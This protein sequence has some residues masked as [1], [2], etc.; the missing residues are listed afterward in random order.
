MAAISTTGDI[1]MANLN[2]H[3]GSNPG[4][5]NISPRVARQAPW[6]FIRGQRKSSLDFGEIC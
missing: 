3:P 5:S 2:R 4:T 1:A 6:I